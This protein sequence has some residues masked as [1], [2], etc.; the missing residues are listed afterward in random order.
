VTGDRRAVPHLQHLLGY[1][2][3]ALV[4]LEAVADASDSD[5]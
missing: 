2:E 5:A 4:E 1:L 3:E